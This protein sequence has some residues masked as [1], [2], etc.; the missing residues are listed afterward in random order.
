MGIS[1]K[2]VVR[3]AVVV[4]RERTGRSNDSLG[5]SGKIFE[6][7]AAQ[8]SRYRDPGF[9]P[10]SREQDGD[11]HG[12]DGVKRIASAWDALG[13]ARP[14]SA[15]RGSGRSWAGALTRREKEKARAKNRPTQAD[16]STLEPASS[17]VCPGKASG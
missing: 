8:C 9:G 12:K 14:S 1:R 3:S 2:G 15:A 4:W 17:H 11:R 6:L 7:R 10:E 5:C 16:K 13:V